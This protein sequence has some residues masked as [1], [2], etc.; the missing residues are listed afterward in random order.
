MLPSHPSV[1]RSHSL[2]Y[3]WHPTATTTTN[4][5][6]NQDDYLRALREAAKDPVLFEKFVAQQADAKLLDD[7]NDDNPTVSS[8]R[9]KITQSQEDSESKTNS[10]LDEGKGKSGY[11]RVE[12]WD[13]ERKER[14]IMTQDERM[15]YEAQRQGNGV[16]QN[17]ILRRNLHS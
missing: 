8:S 5:Y 12:D 4:L 14:G 15:Q 11:T 3:Q 16:K 13:R 1:S 2:S 9:T 10:T 6:G 17:D 7:P